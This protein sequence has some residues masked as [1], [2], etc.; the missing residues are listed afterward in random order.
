MATRDSNIEIEGK[1]L[2][3]DPVAVVEKLI[4]L[5]ATFQKKYHYKRYVFDTI[6]KVDN[7][8]VRLRTDGERTTL[9]VK[10]IA[11]NSMTGTKEWEVDVTSI[12]DT[13]V[14]LSKIGLKSKAVQEN[15]RLMFLFEQTEIAVD[16]WPQLEPYL[17]IE[18]DSESTIRD[19]ARNLGYSE[20]NLDGVNTQQLYEDAGINLDATPELVFDKIPTSIQTCLDII[21]SAV[22]QINL[23]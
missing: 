5:G 8:W 15:Y 12:E 22:K 10:E 6:P 14:I 21:E 2:R 16:F 11:N 3:I 13:L 18:S 23:Q 7:C 19:I 4:N 20:V 1:L 17:E 9:A